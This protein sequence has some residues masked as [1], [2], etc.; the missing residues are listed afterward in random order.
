MIMSTSVGA[1]ALRGGV[2]CPGSPGVD[3]GGGTGTWAVGTG[4]V[5]HPTTTHQRFPPRHQRA[6]QSR[7]FCLGCR[8]RSV[9]CRLSN[10]NTTLPFE[11]LKNK[12]QTCKP[13]P[14]TGCPGFGGG[15]RDGGVE[16]AWTWEG[17]PGQRASCALRCRR[18]LPLSRGFCPKQRPG[19]D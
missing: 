10:G 14:I 6:L 13:S 11:S 1:E 4:P 17:L 9:F 7:I 19:G 15:L 5:L 8:F 12:A 16:L 3:S 18:P 2:A